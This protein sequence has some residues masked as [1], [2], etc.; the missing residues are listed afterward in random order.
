MKRGKLSTVF[1]VLMVILTLFPFMVFAGG[2]KEETSEPEKEISTPAP[3]KEAPAPAK[4]Y[5]GLILPDGTKMGPME[6]LTVTPGEDPT[7]N[8][9]AVFLAEWWKKLG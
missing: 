7:L 8:Q 6:I 1:V 9:E 3:E 4:I 2:Q 5:K